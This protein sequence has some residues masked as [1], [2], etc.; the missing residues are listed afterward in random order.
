MLKS[1]AQIM[2]KNLNTLDLKK[3]TS[4]GSDWE[5]SEYVILSKIKEWSSELHRN[6][7]FPAIEESIQLNLALEDILRENIECKLWFDDQIRLREIN[8]RF[9]VYEKANQIGR[10]LD[11]LLYFIEWALK[12]NKPVLEEARIIKGFVDENLTI[13]RFSTVEQNYH[14]KGYFTLPDNKNELLNVYM[15]ELFWDWSQ[16]DL[17]QKLDSRIVRSIPFKAIQNPLEDLMI[18]F[19]NNSQDLFEPV[20]YF[21]GTDLDFPYEE[22]LFPIAEEKLVQYLSC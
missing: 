17:Y 9:S 21:I 2:G 4:C 3:L 13:N 22:T 5:S 18:D 16:E 19:I 7:L 6:K 1:A 10:Q 8:E 20:V 14:G 12:L 15:Y 11:K